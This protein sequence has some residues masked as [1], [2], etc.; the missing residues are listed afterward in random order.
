MED[1]LRSKQTKV[2]PYCGKTIM[3]SAKKCRYCGEWIQETS[4]NNCTPEF[5]KIKNLD[6]SKEDLRNNNKS[7]DIQGT[8]FPKIESSKRTANPKLYIIPLLLTI[9]FSSIMIYNSSVII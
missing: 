8:S 1:E 2:C 7:T 4:E 9:I 6:E 3:T 5:Q